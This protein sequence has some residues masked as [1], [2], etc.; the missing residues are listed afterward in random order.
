MPYVDKATGVGTDLF[1]RKVRPGATVGFGYV[2]D[3][4]ENGVK[5]DTIT[6]KTKADVFDTVKEFKAKYNTNRAFQNE[7]QYHVT[8]KTKEERGE[9]AME[10]IT[11]SLLKKASVIQDL[12]LRITSPDSPIKTRT[13]S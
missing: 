5:Q 4:Y 11:K 13:A 7:I 8:Y 3:V 1:I 9:T 2:I 12:I 10:D 6:K